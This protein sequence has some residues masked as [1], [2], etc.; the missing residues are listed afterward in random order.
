MDSTPV[1]QEVDMILSHHQLQV[2][3]RDFNEDFCQWGDI[4]VAQG[5]ILHPG[6]ITLDPL[7]EDTFGACVKLSLRD[8]FQEDGLAQRRLVVPFEV[9]ERDRLEVLSVQKSFPIE[10]PLENGNYALYFEI[11][12]DKEVYCRLTFVAT[13]E[14]IQ[15]KF[16]MNDDWGAI[17][18]QLIVEGY[19]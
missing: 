9:M 16:L 1:T 13:E 6:Y 15:P 4:N 19:R 7:L 12:V 17:E 10:L 8:Q 11:A 5:V 14:R 18:D 3:S 2:R